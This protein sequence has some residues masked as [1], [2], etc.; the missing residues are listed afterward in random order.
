M[1]LHENLSLLKQ[2]L[3]GCPGKTDAERHLHLNTIS[4]AKIVSYVNYDVLATDFF[5]VFKTFHCLF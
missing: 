2:N 4:S 3:F 5:K 1:A